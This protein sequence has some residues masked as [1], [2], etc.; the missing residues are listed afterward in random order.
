MLGLER[1]GK[2]YSLRNRKGSWVDIR[3]FGN[4]LQ[5]KAKIPKNQ[6]EGG[7]GIPMSGS[8]KSFL[9]CVSNTERSC[10]DVQETLDKT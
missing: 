8:S 10:M 6:Q 7:Y 3:F 2:M 9:Y 5:K 1:Q 4:F